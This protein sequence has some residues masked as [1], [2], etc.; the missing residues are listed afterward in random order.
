MSIVPA[1]PQ[2]YFLVGLTPLTVSTNYPIWDSLSNPNETFDSSEHLYRGESGEWKYWVCAT[3]FTGCFYS[4]EGVWTE[5]LHSLWN[6]QPHLKTT[7][8][9]P[10]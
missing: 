9:G 6:G 7:T 2:P 10:V 3:P 5:R 4:F 1:D 8:K